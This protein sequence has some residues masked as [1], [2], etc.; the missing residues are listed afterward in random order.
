MILE[1]YIIL[2]NIFEIWKIIEKEDRFVVAMAKEGLGMGRK[3]M[4]LL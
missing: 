3:Q 4:C 2:D 1:S